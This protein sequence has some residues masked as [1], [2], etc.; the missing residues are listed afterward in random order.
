MARNI[1]ATLS[2]KNGNFFANI[3]SASSAVDSFKNKLSGG[4]TNLKSFGSAA[5]GIKS[6]LNS[7]K[8]TIKGVMTTYATLSSLKGLGEL[9]DEMSMTK[10]RL[11]MVNDGLQTNAELNDM[12]F[13]AAK[14]SR[15][16]YKATA[17]L[18]TSLRNNCGTIFESTK[19][20]VTFAEQLN[21]R[22]AIA[23]TSSEAA[24]NA[25][26]QLSQGLAAGAL[27][28]D[29]LNSV[30]EQAPNIARSIESYMGIAQGSIKEAAEQGLVT[31]DVV[32]NAILSTA[33]ET[34]AQFESMPQTWGSIWQGIKTTALQAS[35]GILTSIN[36]VANSETMQGLITK[37]TD[38][39]NSL[40][41]S[42]VLEGFIN[43]M[44]SGA[45]SAINLISGIYTNWDKVK[46][47]VG[48]VGG[49]ML[50]YKG[51]ITGC[52][53]A[54]KAL[55][56]AEIIGN[57]LKAAKKLAVSGLI[58]ATVIYNSAMNSSLVTKTKSALMTAKETASLV[59]HKGA[60][61]A[62]TAATK[63]LAV[64][65]KLLN[66][67]F[68]SS[69]IGWV[70]LIIGGLVAVFVTLWN[71]CEGF[72]N[73]WINLWDGIK[74]VA[75]S[76]CT[77][78]KNVTSTS[79]ETLKS[80]VAEKLNNIKAAYE[81]HGGGIKGIAAATM[82]GIKEY[83]TFG[84]DYIDNLTGGKLTAIKDKFLSIWESAKNGV[85]NIWSGIVDSIKG[86]INNAI[87][88][89]NNGLNT[90]VRGINGLIR[91]I[92]NISSKVGIPAIPELKA[93]QLSL[94]A[95]GGILTRATL[96]G[97][98]GRSAL[99]GGEAGA[100]AVLPLSTF[101]RQLE[102]FTLRREAA[103]GVVNN[104]NIYVTVQSNGDDDET[105][106]NKVARRIVKILENM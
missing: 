42:G 87:K 93:P 88:G 11:D 39:I 2:L 97:F 31:A 40:A 81:E 69:P 51:I 54:E 37:V 75:S 62:S 89:I 25:I 100:E 80:T 34:N 1:G 20:T 26:T 12:I 105:L 85:A 45:E 9:S 55:N 82:T 83:Y 32:K 22:F 78:V 86:A 104:N 50:A 4:V 13:Q 10:A 101:W 16:Q 43:N 33:D 70:I 30:L 92:N 67:A 73:F 60:V 68:V 19:E 98:S 46:V 64:G 15:G 91:G 79:F 61:I 5:E 72:R 41:S 21:K 71:K 66:A 76:A 18:V 77:T 49:A 53:I 58:N 35:D 23:G 95:N 63:A 48:I 65:Q 103:G 6:P 90:S 52:T 44:V 94:L 8:D 17:D 99:V 27:R 57:G 3:K 38:G 74:S 28:G 7:L 24:S 36:N 102:K 96:F 106:A 14:N 59:I 29:E 47:I 84:Y 56:A